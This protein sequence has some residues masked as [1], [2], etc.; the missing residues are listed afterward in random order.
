[1]YKSLEHKYEKGSDTCGWRLH[2][3]LH[4]RAAVLQKNCMN[5]NY[6]VLCRYCSTQWFSCEYN[7]SLGGFILFPTGSSSSVASAVLPV[8]VAK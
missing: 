8:H 1:M 7:T 5:T 3:K 2:L 4:N 6:K